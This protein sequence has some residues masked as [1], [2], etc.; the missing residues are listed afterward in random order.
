MLFPWS[1]C[2][3]KQA[4]IARPHANALGFQ[5]PPAY[6]Q[7]PII[8]PPDGRFLQSEG[9]VQ[10][11]QGFPV[12]GR[13][14]VYLGVN[15]PADT[16]AQFGTPDAGT[17]SGRMIQYQLWERDWYGVDYKPTSTYDMVLNTDPLPGEPVPDFSQVYIDQNGNVTT[18]AGS[19][20]SYI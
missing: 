2:Y 16:T 19:D 6:I 7:D 8:T 10:I 4:I 15:N 9:V 11:A 14:G 20:Q 3:K 13:D 1:K 12:V 17:V 5:N 18:L